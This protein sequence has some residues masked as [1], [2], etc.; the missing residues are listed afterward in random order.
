MS[1]QCYDKVPRSW[2]LRRWEHDPSTNTLC[3]QLA[4]IDSP[5]AEGA[6]TTWWHDMALSHAKAQHPMIGCAHR[7]RRVRPMAA[8]RS[9]GCPRSAMHSGQLYFFSPRAALC[10]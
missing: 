4:G 6:C 7:V 10:M 1:Q 9:A 8:S 5:F 3:L 2:A